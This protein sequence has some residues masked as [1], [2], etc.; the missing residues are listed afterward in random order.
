MH[1]L[2]AVW[3][4]RRANVFGDSAGRAWDTRRVDT[5]AHSLGRL[6]SFGELPDA[7]Q[8]FIQDTYQDLWGARE[9]VQPLKEKE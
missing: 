6:V 8:S 4:K 2:D 1:L 5:G 9:P 3:P 7:C